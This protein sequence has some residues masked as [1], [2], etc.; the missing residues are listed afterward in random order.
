MLTVCT[1]RGR[2]QVDVDELAEVQMAANVIAMPTFQ[3]YKQGKLIDHTTGAS[4]HKLRA[5]VAN[6]CGES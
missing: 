5:M 4:E 1:D 2:G 6:A 3:V